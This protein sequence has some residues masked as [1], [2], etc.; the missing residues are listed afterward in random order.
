MK[1]LSGTAELNKNMTINECEVYFLG[2]KASLAD[3]IF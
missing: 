1:H 2:K 3:D